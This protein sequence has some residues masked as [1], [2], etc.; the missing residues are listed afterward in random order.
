MRPE[1]HEIKLFET[2]IRCHAY[3][4]CGE[5]AVYLFLKNFD[6]FHLQR[7]EN[8]WSSGLV[9]VHMSPLGSLRTI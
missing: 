6:W 4:A 8:I 3:C 7:E 9:I 1:I 5:V 2:E